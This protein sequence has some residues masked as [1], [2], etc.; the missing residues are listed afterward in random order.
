M[1]IFSIVPASGVI[2]SISLAGQA[3]FDRGKSATAGSHRQ[4]ASSLCSPELR[5][6]RVGAEAGGDKIFGTA[7]DDQFLSGRTERRK[8]E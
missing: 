2:L 8:G 3:E 7:D 1:A 6:S 4:Q 5:R